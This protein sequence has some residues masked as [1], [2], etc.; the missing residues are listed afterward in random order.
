[1][2][3][4]VVNHVK[5]FYSRSESS[6]IN[7]SKIKFLVTSRPYDDLEKLFQ[8][9]PATAAYMRFD[10]DDKS[11]EIRREIDLVIDERVGD[12]I[13]D[14]PIKDQQ[15]ISQRLKSMEH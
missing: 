3:R 12:I 1:M 13:A 14:F 4:S 2:I 5:E 6:L 9:F 10:G 8:R 7:S 15:K 11:E